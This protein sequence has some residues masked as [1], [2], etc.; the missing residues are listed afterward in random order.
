MAFGE[1]S[2]AASEVGVGKDTEKNTGNTDSILESANKELGSDS[3]VGSG[4]SVNNEESTLLVDIANETLGQKSDLNMPQNDLQNSEKDKSPD[5]NTGLK[6]TKGKNE[7]VSENVEPMNLN[8]SDDQNGLSDNHEDKKESYNAAEHREQKA[9]NTESIPERIKCL[10]EHLEGQKHPETGVP[11]ERKIIEVNGK[12]YEVVVPKFESPF[13]VQLSENLYE[14]TDRV[15]FKECNSQL[16]NGIATNN[17]LREQFDDEQLD[18]IENGD[19]PDG[20]TWHH[21][22]E[23]GKIQLVDSDI[24][25][26]TA[27]T[28]GRYIWGGGNEKR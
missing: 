18:Q 4:D 17:D 1:I 10:N 3:E 20:F 7:D 24:H 25:N 23:A 26:R 19:T 12:Q 13:D 14:A 5:K 27:H 11:F 15:Q 28:G 8:D 2:E 21:D 16:K 9:D 22:A 6:E